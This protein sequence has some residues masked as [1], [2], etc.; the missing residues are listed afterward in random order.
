MQG[1]LT[2]SGFLPMQD[3]TVDQ[4]SLEGSEEGIQQPQPKETFFQ[5]FAQTGDR[6]DE[7]FNSDEIADIIREQIW[8]NPLPL[9]YGEV[10][11]SSAFSLL[12][13]TKGPCDCGDVLE[14]HMVGRFSKLRTLSEAT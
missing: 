1:A 13:K 12:M 11:S 9:Y 8:P 2:N 7:E 10:V 3:L 4:R 14:M 6:Q 5:W